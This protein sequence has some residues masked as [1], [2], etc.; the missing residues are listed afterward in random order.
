MSSR[1]ILGQ[2]LLWL[3]SGFMFKLPGLH[4][5]AFWL[6]KILSLNKAFVAV[7]F[8]FSIPQKFLKV[9]HNSPLRI[10]FLLTILAEQSVISLHLVSSWHLLNS[11]GWVFASLPRTWCPT[12]NKMSEKKCSKTIHSSLSH[13]SQLRK[14]RTCL[15]SPGILAVR[16]GY[17]D[18]HLPDSIHFFP[19]PLGHCGGR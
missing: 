15:K 3:A 2:F 12:K 10:S 14:E 4:L 18:P 16:P 8:R 11:P 19:L 13:F 1:G 17:P 6:L 5:T 7:A 9:D